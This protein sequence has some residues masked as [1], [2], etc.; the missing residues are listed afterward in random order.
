VLSSF[1]TRLSHEHRALKA[2][3]L[4]QIVAECVACLLFANSCGSVLYVVPLIF[5]SCSAKHGLRGTY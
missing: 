3:V 4:R 1:I 2:L 5:I